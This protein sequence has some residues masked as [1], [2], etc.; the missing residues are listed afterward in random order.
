MHPTCS[1]IPVGPMLTRD[2]HNQG[3]KQGSGKGRDSPPLLSFHTRGSQK[4]TCG[5]QNLSIISCILNS[6]TMT[7]CINS[8]LVWNSY[9]TCTCVLLPFVAHDNRAWLLEDHMPYRLLIEVINWFS[10]FRCFYASYTLGE[11]FCKTS[12]QVEMDLKNAKRLPYICKNTQQ[13]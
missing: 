5:T 2:I 11:K 4:H 9:S 8:W 6:F 12:F 7:I 10:Y 1:C 3:V 13:M